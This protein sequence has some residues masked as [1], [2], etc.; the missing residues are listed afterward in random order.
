MLDQAQNGLGNL[1]AT[2]HS[3]LNFVGVVF[4]FCANKLKINYLEPMRNGLPQ[5]AAPLWSIAA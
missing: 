4:W 2:N 3:R 5:N 1:P